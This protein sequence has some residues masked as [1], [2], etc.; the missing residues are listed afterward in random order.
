MDQIYKTI[1]DWPAILQGVIGAGLF[2]MLVFFGQR[3]AGLCTNTWGKTTRKRKK[4]ELM[5]QLVRYHALS[6]ARTKDA[7]KGSYYVSVLLLRS[8]RD[9]IKG[10]L[11]VTFGLL[12]ESVLDVFGAIGFA[13]AV[14]YFL[15]ALNVV[16]SIKYDGDLDAKIKELETELER[17]ADV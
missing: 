17:Y 6:A 3:L 13:G 11:W 4:L 12:F 1:S 15:S 7:T 2:S 16:K 5:N 9:L 8:S 10:F 14:Y